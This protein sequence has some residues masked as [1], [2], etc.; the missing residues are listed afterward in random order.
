MGFGIS[1][2]RYVELYLQN[3]KDVIIDVVVEDVL[4]VF[5]LGK[6]HDADGDGQGHDFVDGLQRHLTDHQRRHLLPGNDASQ[7]QREEDERVDAFA[8]DGAEDGSRGERSPHPTL[9]VGLALLA[10][11]QFHSRHHVGV[12]ERAAD[13]GDKR[14][15]GDAW[16]ESENLVEALFTV[17]V[18]CPWYPVGDGSHDDEEEVHGEAHP[19]EHTGT[20]IAPH[21]AHHIVDDVAHGKHDVSNTFA[22]IRQTQNSVPKSINSTLTFFLLSCSIVILVLLKGVHPKASQVPLQPSAIKRPAT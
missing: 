13:E 3:I 4:L 5:L 19:D 8:K 22:V 15:Q 11:R 2:C 21:L 7:S 1:V 9:Q 10:R 17:P 14:R 20:A 16:C 6:L 12:H 18:V